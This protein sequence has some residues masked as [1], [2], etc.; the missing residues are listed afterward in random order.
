MDSQILHSPT[1]L[2]SDKVTFREEDCLLSEHSGGVKSPYLK[3][4]IQS[5]NREN[6]RLSVHVQQ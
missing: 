1:F 2:K 4:S 3:N 5:T 6:T